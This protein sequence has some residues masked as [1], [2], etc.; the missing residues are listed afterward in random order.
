MPRKDRTVGTEAMSEQARPREGQQRKIG[1]DV[2]LVEERGREEN[3]RSVACVEDPTVD[4]FY[5]NVAWLEAVAE[6]REQR[7]VVGPVVDDGM[8]D[9]R[10]GPI[11]TGA[12][13][14]SAMPLEGAQVALANQ[15][16]KARRCLRII[17]EIM[18]EE[19]SADEG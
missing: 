3:I 6:G 7:A 14:G 19:E 11:T 10:K 5:R 8:P 13:G 15:S 17:R 2:R 1:A 4:R 16:L 18:C 12:Y 9:T